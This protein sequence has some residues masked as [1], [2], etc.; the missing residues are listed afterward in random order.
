MSLLDKILHVIAFGLVIA[1]FLVLGG[2]VM[3]GGMTNGNISDGMHRSGWFAERSWTWAPA[4][5]TLGLTVVL[6]LVII[7]KKE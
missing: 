5:I 2:G 7:K 4:L 1:L 3:T 6:G